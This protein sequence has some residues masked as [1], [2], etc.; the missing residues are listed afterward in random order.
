MTCF[1]FIPSFEALSSILETSFSGS[2]VL[3]LRFMYYA[4]YVYYP[5]RQHLFSLCPCACN[6]NR[7]ANTVNTRVTYMKNKRRIVTFEPETDVDLMLERARA[8]G[9]LLTEIIN[10]SLKAQGPKVIKRLARERATALTELSGSFNPPVTQDDGL[11]I[12]A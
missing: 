12:A 5:T 6:T 10:R 1:S 8:S 11:A 2:N 9:L 7:Y 3:M 4:Y